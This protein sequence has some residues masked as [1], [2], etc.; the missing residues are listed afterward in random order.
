MRDD[1]KQTEP[2]QSLRK[3]NV[4][5]MMLYLLVA[6]ILLIFIRLYE[7]R[8]YHDRY[9]NVEREMAPGVLAATQ[10]ALGD[11][12]IEN[13]TQVLS[14]DNRRTSYSGGTHLMSGAKNGIPYS[15]A[16]DIAVTDPLHA[17]SDV[18]KL[19]MQGIAAWRRGPG[20][21]GGAQNMAPHIHCVWAGAPTRNVEN[22]EQ[23]SSFIHGYKGIVCRN[24][25]HNAWRDPSIQPSE[26]AA[27]KNLCYATFHSRRMDSIEPYEMRHR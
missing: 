1:L 18:H 22:L 3:G 21:P 4:R 23:I 10:R 19:R 8:I 17:D 5:R 9:R 26:I 13:I 11:N 27:V 20:A 6:L 7:I 16:F 14:F 25:D 2:T 15:L 12:A 24:P